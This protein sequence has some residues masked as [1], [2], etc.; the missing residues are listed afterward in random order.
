MKPRIS[1]VCFSKHGFVSDNVGKV[2]HNKSLKVKLLLV[3]CRDKLTIEFACPYMSPS[4][5]RA[6]ATRLCILRS[7]IAVGSGV[8]K[9]A[10]TLEINTT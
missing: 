9:M 10:W 6:Y 2:H 5:L 3:I 8:G 4:T 1:W 7:S